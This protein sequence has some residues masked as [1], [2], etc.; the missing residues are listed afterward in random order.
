V[1]VGT[2][3]WR[4]WCHARHEALWAQLTGDGFEAYGMSI[5]RVFHDD[6]INPSPA[7]KLGDRKCD[8]LA[9]SG[10]I[11]YASYGSRPQPG[12]TEDAIVDK[13]K[14]DFTGAVTHWDSFEE[15]RFVT[16]ARC[17]PKVAA[18]ITR[19][20]R[21]HGPDCERPIRVRLWASADD[22]WINMISRLAEDQVDLIYPGRP[23]LARV[24][25]EDLQP[26]L[27]ALGTQ[28]YPL[29]EVQAINE[30]PVDKMDFNELSDGTRLE[31]GEGRRFAP[32]IDYWYGQQSEADLY[33]RHGARFK[34]IYREHAVVHTSP[35]EIMEAIYI[36]L[37]GPSFRMDD[38]LANS[39]YTVTSYFFDQCHIF[40]TRPEEVG[41]IDVVAD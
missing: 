12:S 23:G 10:R 22:L 39:V 14:S 1:S 38:R 4:E 37:A 6:F 15:W 8:G 16:N 33:D 17:G 27:E 9:N 21:E 2:P 13:I 19:L 11:F 41:E 24:E 35:T 5:Y 29:E 32:R 40:E 18:L 36:S 20:Q 30:V 25:L 7:G 28:T 31:I 3:F 34:E 26:L